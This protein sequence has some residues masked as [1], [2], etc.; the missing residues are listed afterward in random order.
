MRQVVGAVPSDRM[1]VILSYCFVTGGF[2]SVD[3]NQNSVP[4]TRWVSSD[5][6]GGFPMSEF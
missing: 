3:G 1:C 6:R 2:T 4:L 5:E